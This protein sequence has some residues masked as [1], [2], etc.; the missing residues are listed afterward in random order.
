TAMPAAGGAAPERIS[1]RARAM[2]ERTGA[3]LARAT[4]TGPDGRVIAR[5]VQAL[6][7]AGQVVTPAARAGYAG[8]GEGTGLGG[9]VTLAD[10]DRPDAPAEQTAPVVPAAESWDEPLSNMRKVIARAMT[11]SLSSMAQL[12]HHSSFD[13]TQI[14]ALRK[15]LKE[16]G[17]PFGLSKVTLNDIVLYAVA[18]TLANPAFKALNAHLIDGATMRYFKGVHLGVAVDTERGLMVPTIFGADRMSLAQISQA[19]K[20]LAAECQAGTINPD[21]LR[22]GTFT[23]SNLGAL[24]TESFTP[25]INPPQTAILGVG[26]ITTRVRDEGGSLA[27]YPA[28]GLSLTY[29]H[30]ALDGAPASR[31]LKALCENLEHFTLLLAKG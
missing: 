3:D 27:G 6:L 5:D 25:V 4:A 26:S 17:E 22:G 1:P 11:A 24:G 14:Q 19:A 12:T 31:F 9:R 7:D 30:R 20:Q 2:A 29:D 10:L 21:L 13:A 18:R 23:V 16:G 8:G 28:M 15:Q